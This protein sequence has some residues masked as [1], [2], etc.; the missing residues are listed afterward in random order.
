MYRLKR[1]AK[2]VILESACFIKGLLV[3]QIFDM[4]IY[5]LKKINMYAI[6]F[7]T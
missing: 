1:G 2:A 6:L 3:E 5:I 4:R 7:V